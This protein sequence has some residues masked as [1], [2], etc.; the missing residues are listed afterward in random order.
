LAL[1]LRQYRGAG[2]TLTR[3]IRKRRVSAGEGAPASSRSGDNGPL[4][5]AWTLWLGFAPHTASGELMRQLSKL[6]VLIALPLLAAC[7]DKAAA[8]EETAQDI[9]AEAVADGDVAIQWDEWG[10]PHIASGDIAGAFYGLGWAHMQLHGDLI[11]ELYGRA[12][13]RGAEYWGEDYELR[14]RF[15]RALGV[16]A[17]AE[18]WWEAQ[19]PAYQSYLE[20]YALGMNDFAAAH[21][22]L[23]DDERE[24]ALPVLPTDPLAHIQLAIH[25]TFIAGSAPEIA[26][27]WALQAAPAAAESGNDRGSN[28]WAIGPSRSESGNAILLAN[29]HLPWSDLFYFTE[30]QMTAPDLDVYGVTLVGIP[31][32]AIG[33]NEHLGWTHTVNTFDGMDLYELQMT[34]DGSYLLDGEEVPLE[35]E[36]QTMLVRLDDGTME[37]RLTTIANSV[38]GPVLALAR[39]HALAVRVV[40][41]DRANM[42]QQYVEMGLA[43]NREEFTAALGQGQM[44]M[45][46]TIYADANGEIAYYFNAAMPQRNVGNWAV[47][48]SILPGT[49]SE[50]LWTEYH[51]F[52]DLP[53]YANPESGFVQNAN[54]PP[55]TST[56]P[57]AVTHDQYPAYFAPQ[58]MPFRPQHSARL[59]LSDSSI[60]FDEV[61]D[62]ANDTT[63]D[64]AVR[65]LPE[66]IDRLEAQDDDRAR[67]AARALRGWNGRADLDSQGAALFYSWVVGVG[68]TAAFF[69][70]TWDPNHPLS[71]PYALTRSDE[72]FDALYTVV[73]AMDAAGVALEAPYGDMF[74]LR[75]AGQDLPAS[76]GSEALGSFRT[77]WFRPAGDGTYSLA[78]GNTFVAE[79][80]FSSPIRARGYLAY[81]NSTQEGDARMGDQLQLFS[82]AE[83]RDIHFYGDDIAAHT[84]ETEVLHRGE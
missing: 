8:P 17:R 36:D 54:D 52:S 43:T 53:Q 35:L 47:W 13:G 42:M 31:F 20:A 76:A 22:E 57:R 4:G 70:D 11:L 71:T 9:V 80:E 40:G 6:I 3:K 38:F 67:R 73:D 66:L 84:V 39:G 81:G 61:R 10:V 14:D 28:A 33:F 69:D 12:R 41:L 49:T 5:R 2:I 48:Q 15:T 68:S 77:G 30:A 79:V 26:R 51:P 16:P 27:Q 37:E 50:F 24:R 25:G 1:T 23:I 45:F 78:G 21:P 44:P 60:T 46:N 62:Y 65:I 19:G 64:M 34:P 29:P 82:D 56:F 32:V 63:L 7:G 74:R 72:I 75:Y 59:M 18:E 58:G 55:W 83:W